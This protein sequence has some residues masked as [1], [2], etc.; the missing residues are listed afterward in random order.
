M[1]PIALVLDVGAALHSFGTGGKAFVQ[2]KPLR[3]LL[4]H[5]FNVTK[6]EKIFAVNPFQGCFGFMSELRR[7]NSEFDLDTQSSMATPEK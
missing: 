7:K 5:G 1:S 6:K 2:A 4:L 3:W